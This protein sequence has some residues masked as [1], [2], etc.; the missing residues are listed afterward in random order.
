VKAAGKALRDSGQHTVDELWE[1]QR[2]VVEWRGVH[3]YPLNTAQVSLRRR[4]SDETGRRP[5][6]TQRLK[7]LPSIVAKLRR[8]APRTQL[9]TLQDIAGCR[10]ILSSVDEVNRLVRRFI[11]SGSS[12]S[13]VVGI[14]DYVECPAASG[15]RGVHLI[16]EYYDRP[17]ERRQASR[18]D[19]VADRDPARVGRRRRGT[20][21]AVRLR[22][23][24]EPRS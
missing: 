16:T 14:D 8:G 15:Y 23:Q 21:E 4:I 10:G 17:T 6:V 2:M 9:T 5:E 13:N 18:R 1:A 3:A 7:E 24:A 22:S 19:P 11:R 20:R 12:K